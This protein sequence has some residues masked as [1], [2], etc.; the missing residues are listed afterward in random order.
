M[1]LVFHFRRAGDF[2]PHC[3]IPGAPREYFNQI[4]WMTLRIRVSSPPSSSSSIASSNVWIYHRVT[5]AGTTHYNENDLHDGVF[6]KRPAAVLACMMRTLAHLTGAPART[7]NM[8]APRGAKI[9][10]L[11]NFRMTMYT[12]SGLFMVMW[13]DSLT[14]A[15]CCLDVKRIFFLINCAHLQE[16]GM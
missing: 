3:I 6:C 4:I 11:H 5:K 15:M 7:H 8:I 12:E 16:I 1:R 9:S 10:F 2:L 13:P 14:H